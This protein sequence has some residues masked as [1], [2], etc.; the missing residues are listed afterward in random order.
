MSH[1][2][3]VDTQTT[4]I[5]NQDT[6]YA[7]QWGTGEII[8]KYLALAL[9]F[10]A[11]RAVDA[12]LEI[13]VGALFARLG[14]KELAASSLISAWQ[15]FIP[16]TVVSFVYSMSTPLAKRDQDVDVGKIVRHGI[17]V[18]IA[19]SMPVA[20]LTFF[21]GS[22][23]KLFG[24][25][26]EVASLVNDFY[27]CGIVS[28]PGTFLATVQQQ[29]TLGIEHPTISL[30]TT[31][32]NDG[33][34]LGVGSIFTFGLLGAPRLGVQGMGLGY[35]I[36]SLV[37][38]SGAAALFLLDKK[39]FGRYELAKCNFFDWQLIK[40]LLTLGI[41]YTF[42]MFADFG[43]AYF[44][45]F[46]TGYLGKESLSATRIADMVYLLPLIML[47]RC[48]TATC[49]LAGRAIKNNNKPLFKGFVYTN[50][51]GLEVLN[52]VWMILGNVLSKQLIGFFVDIEDPANAKIVALAKTMLWVSPLGLYPEV[53]RYAIAGV[54]R[55]NSD[56]KSS[57]YNSLLWML[58]LGFPAVV[59][60]YYSGGGAAALY[61]ARNVVLGGAAGSMLY[62]LIKK[63]GSFFSSD[64]PQD[65]QPGVFSRICGGLKSCCNF[66]GS[67]WHQRGLRQQYQVIHDPI[68]QIPVFINGDE[69]RMLP[70]VPQDNQLGIFSRIGSGLGSCCFWCHSKSDHHT[71]PD[72][73]HIDQSPSFQ[74]S[75]AQSLV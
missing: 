72:S 27:R 23:L 24:Q 37:T 71:K 56:V 32:I 55:S 20:A 1:S 12:A 66:G 48:P 11:P 35:S 59:A 16:G 42:Q 38:T 68:N 33:L 43:M 46:M 62:T 65:N 60:G 30:V 15:R 9:P 17:T 52:A 74:V 39:H 61:A 25:D 70:A 6:N 54:L 50:V 13:G 14:V 36:A 18:A 67:F 53:L 26:Q 22:I 31:I 2:N 3:P 69:P 41:P 58:V 63:V 28:V 19:T 49:Y 57:M 8:K 75:E 21:S 5:A 44:A 40:Q 73:L 10:S 47:I 29:F 4:A 34:A 64:I 7:R 45:N 51:F